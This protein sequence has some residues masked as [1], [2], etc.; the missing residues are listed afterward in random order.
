MIEPNYSNLVALFEADGGA[1][2]NVA[3][4][5]IKAFLVENIKT[6]DIPVIA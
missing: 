3:R 1:W 5:S 6:L 2:R 4:Q